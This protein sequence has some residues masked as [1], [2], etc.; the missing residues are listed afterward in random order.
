MILPAVLCRALFELMPFTVNT[1][2][3]EENH[4]AI[5][6]VQPLARVAV[7]QSTQNDDFGFA[8]FH[9]LH[10]F[11]KLCCYG[12]VLINNLRCFCMG[13]TFERDNTGVAYTCQANQL[14][15][16]TRFLNANF[17]S[18][19][20]SGNFLLALCGSGSLSF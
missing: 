12:F 9:D 4:S 11:A 14:Y 20:A 16:A 17:R 6:Y 13:Q 5:A 15:K 18:Y 2:K 19:D 1:T 7:F 8:V 3:P 10:S